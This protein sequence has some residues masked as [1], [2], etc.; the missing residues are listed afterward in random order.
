[1]SISFKASSSFDITL[2]DSPTVFNCVFMC[3]LI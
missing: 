1:M 3:C 2:T